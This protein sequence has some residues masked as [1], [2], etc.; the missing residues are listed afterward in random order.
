MYGHTNNRDNNC[1]NCN[2]T[3]QWY[4]PHASTSAYN[5]L[6]DPP[7]RLVT[8]EFITYVQISRPFM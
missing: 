4:P 2:M 8:F 3:S 5:F 1:N 7:A 6:M